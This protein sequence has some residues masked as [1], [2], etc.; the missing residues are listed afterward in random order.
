VNTQH[1]IVEIIIHKRD[2]GT[3]TSEELHWVISAYTKGDIPDYQ[4]S[5]LLMAILFR[6][7]D[8][9][10]LASWTEAMLHSGDV[11]DL[12]HIDTPKVDKHSTGGVGDKVSI[13]LAP[14]VAACG[15][16][17]PMISGR[18]LGHT[19]GTLDKLESIPGFRTAL[20]PTEFI[21]IVESHGLVLA[22]QSETLAPAD[23]LIYALR[24]ATGTVP[25][26]PLIA[27]SIMSKKLANGS[28]GLVLDVKVGR[29]AF[30]KTL[31][32]A[33]ELAETMVGIGNAHGT[34]TVA[35]F[36][37][38]DQPLGS[39]IG[40]ASE[41][42]ESIDVLEGHGPEDLVE[43]VYRLGSEMLQLAGVAT[44]AVEAGELLDTAIESGR[45]LERFA[46]VILAQGGDPGVVTD[47]N[48]LP[49]APNVFH[50]TSPRSGYVAAC[51]ALD[52]GVA[53]VRLG[54]GRE[55]KEDEID[56]GVG[57]TVLKK[58]GDPVEDGEPVA[59][60]RYTDR[61]RLDAAA[62]LLKRAWEIADEPQ[63]P[64]PLILGEVR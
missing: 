51:D 39:E 27:S 35:V 18:G 43:V 17:V 12:S 9:G 7:L 29:G 23:R 3:L 38:M 49:R 20:D 30:M 55:R 54:G 34:A 44:D 59:E 41:I 4:M 61:A 58:V 56:A 32:D 22:G 13:S 19:G 50:V 40:N 46:A 16:A 45:A 63:Q 60:I 52:I 53:S 37:A 36:S 62:G 2:G 47:R 24:D 6:G 64:A 26:I 31:D 15:L 8:Q 28:D 14:L 48:L 25:S 10:E 1:S 11:I 57:I 21:N 42:A 33:R 5:A